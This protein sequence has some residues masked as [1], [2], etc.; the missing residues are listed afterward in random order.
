MPVDERAPHQRTSPTD[1]GDAPRLPQVPA[2]D[3]LK[4]FAL[5][6]V[7][8]FH[9]GFTVLKGGFLG[10]STFLTISGFLLTTLL[11]AELSQHGRVSATGFWERRARRLLPLTLLVIA[12]IE[13]LQVTL[14]IGSVATFRGDVLSALGG[15]ANWRF[16][17]SG[18]DYIELLAERSPVQHLWAVSVAEQIYLL[19]PLGLILLMALTGHRWRTA[20]AV[21]VAG[22]VASFTAAWV[23]S[24]NEGSVGLAYFGTHTRVGE[25]LVG[26]VLAF[27][28]LTPGLRRLLSTRQGVKA[29]HF[30]GP[31]ALAGLLIL[32][33]TTG[34]GDTRLFHGVTAVNAMLTA[35]VLLAVTTPGPATNALSVRPL[36]FLGRIG[37]AAYLVHWP[38]YLVIDEPRL[39]LNGSLLF[40]LRVAA[41]VAAAAVLTWVVETPFRRGLRV[42]RKQLA[43]GLGST[44]VM[45]AAF[46]LVLPVRPPANVSLTVDDGNGPGDL[47]VVVP[48]GGTTSARM[49]LIGDSLAASLVPGVRAWN[50][51]TPD[52]QLHLDTHIAP[53][54]PPSAPGPVRIVGAEA[55][56]DVAC[57]GWEHRLPKMLEASEADVIV[58]VTGLG[59]LGERDIDHAWRHLGDATYDAWLAEELEEL[60]DALADKG[61]PV[62]WATLPHARLTPPGD[63][64]G[65]W[66]EFDENDPQ[67]AERYNELV[68]EVVGGR[69]GF[70]IIEFDAWTH[71]LPRGEFDPDY[72]QPD[73]TLTDGGAGAAVRWL[74]P[75]VSAAT[76]GDAADG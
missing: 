21:A 3:G 66:T 51:E 27:A 60:A 5:L 76:G 9:Q 75:K 72:R 2:F 63:G 71:E 14:R 50:E 13:A 57:V 11:L 47:D 20:G 33:V 58:V 52:Q 28:M 22:A 43:I 39:N 61:V 64:G 26:S 37:L 32:W 55:G 15:V 4:G 19:V 6:A 29:L 34:V 17:F 69:D 65:S 1:S 74:V 10:I 67:R 44:T 25:L 48:A 42:S 16:A 30:G 35:W 49:L 41:T 40:L 46:V 54:C 70:E 45:L 56:T 68:H 18:S 62:L 23:I 7:L 38:I 73:A 53:D 31:A 59:E 36:R 12:G 8:G 24:S